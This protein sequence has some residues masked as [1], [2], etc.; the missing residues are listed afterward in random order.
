MLELTDISMLFEKKLKKPPPN[1]GI[2]PN[3]KAGRMEAPG[4]ASCTGPVLALG[5]ELV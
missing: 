4:L 1:D 2:S 5:L 3:C